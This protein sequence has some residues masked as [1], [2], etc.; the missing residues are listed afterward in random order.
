MAKSSGRAVSYLALAVALAALAVAL[1]AVLHRPDDSPEYTETERV[2]AKSAICAAF[3]TVRTGVAT[4]TNLEP[5][6]GAD[7]ITGSLAAAA[8]ARVA[9][10]DGGQYLLARLGAA[11][12]EDLAGQIRR[13]ADQLMDIGAA[14]TAGAPN[15]DPAQSARLRNAE[16]LSAQIS[17][18]C[19]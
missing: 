10:Y 3:F 8:N 14:A 4:N 9:L 17:G 2:D 13:F 1:F 18:M 15:T 11:T 19:G 16:D 7:D 5:P 6:G 12:P